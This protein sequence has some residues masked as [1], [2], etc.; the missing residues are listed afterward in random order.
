MKDIGEFDI[1]NRGPGRGVTFTRGRFG[2]TELSSMNLD[3]EY[4]EF[5]LGLQ[6]WLR[7]AL[8]QDVF[9]KATPE[10]REFIVSGLTP[11]VWD[12]I[13]GEEEYNDN[14]LSEEPE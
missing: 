7:G 12:K 1:A 11:E 2:S 4:A 5:V 13:F 3:I 14:E 9:P 6:Q 10:E 8:I